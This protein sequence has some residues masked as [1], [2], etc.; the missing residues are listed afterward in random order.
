MKVLKN[1]AVS[2]SAQFEKLAN[3]FENHEAIASSIIKEVEQI[4][5]KSKV[6][7]N[8]VRAS[9]KTLNYD[10]E[11]TIQDE[12]RWIERAKKVHEIDEKRAIE[13]IKRV[14]TLR[15]NKKDI[16][17]QIKEANTLEK[18]LV[19]NVEK[20]I[21]KL[22]QLKQQKNTLVS[23]QNCAEAIGIFHNC[24]IDFGFEIENL[25]TRWE[26]KVTE[27]E[28]QSGNTTYESDDIEEEF[29]KEEEREEL[30]SLLDEIVQKEYERKE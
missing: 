13:C 5:A 24:N 22:R 18:N 25:F 8:Q 10:L 16:E 19:E 17:K 9:K 30:K 2:L 23:R 3:Q 28:I 12:N 21:T 7:L 27:W 29:I 6:Q 1:I 14:K 4:A 15:E 11:K 26:T 20:I